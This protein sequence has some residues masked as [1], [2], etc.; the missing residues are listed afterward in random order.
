MYTY[1]TVLNGHVRA[2]L[3]YSLAHTGRYHQSYKARDNFSDNTSM[4]YVLSDALKCEKYQ[5]GV[6]THNY[7]QYDRR[8]MLV[9]RTVLDCR[10]SCRVC[11][12]LVTILTHIVRNHQNIHL[13]HTVRIRSILQ[14]LLETIQSYTHY[15]KPISPYSL[16]HTVRIHTVLQTL[17]ESIQSYTHC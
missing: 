7:R 11:P 17:L 5:I 8:Q 12:A 3:I 15:W 10:N 13:T 2:V 14:A 4:D 6:W 16:T 1:S 9:L